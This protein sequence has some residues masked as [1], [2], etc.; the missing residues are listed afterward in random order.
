MMLPV[1]WLT[2]SGRPDQGN[3]GAE[4][5]LLRR[6][7]EPVSVRSVT[8]SDMEI[9]IT[10]VLG[11][12][13]G[14]LVAWLVARV[15]FAGRSAALSTERDLLRERVSNLEAAIGDDAQTATLLAPLRDALVRVERQVGTL[16]RDRVEQFS[17]VSVQLADV[18]TST[19]ALRS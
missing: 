11:L 18:T 6:V 15:L 1:T 2:S 7:E 16:E 12:L 14:A 17:Q 8:V 13:T 5:A 9:S 10:A 4:G 3:P 19:D